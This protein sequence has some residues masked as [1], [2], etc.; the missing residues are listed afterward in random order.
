MRILYAWDV[1][2]KVF[3]RFV[4]RIDKIVELY[5]MCDVPANIIRFTL[6][7]HAHIRSVLRG[8]KWLPLASFTNHR[9]FRRY[10]ITAFFVFISSSSADVNCGCLTGVRGFFEFNFIK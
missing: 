2:R 8:K 3:P 5:F 4:A 6:R 1:T 10:Q 7:A 9:S